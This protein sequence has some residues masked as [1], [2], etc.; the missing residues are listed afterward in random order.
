MFTLD[1]STDPKSINWI[2][3]MGDD[4]GKTLP[5]IYM[6]EG[7]RFVFVAGNEGEPRPTVFE[8]V[9]GQTLRAFRQVES[10]RARS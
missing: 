7:D 2:D 3:S 1:A 8:T 6:L 5:A 4:A 10:A 9:P